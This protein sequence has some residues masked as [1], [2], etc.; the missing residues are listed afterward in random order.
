M[1]YM[2]EH[3]ININI[4][5][6]QILNSYIKYNINYFYNMVL[7]NEQN[8]VNRKLLMYDLH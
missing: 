2:L 4:K 8:N 1:K 3:I 7:F 5:L 6:F